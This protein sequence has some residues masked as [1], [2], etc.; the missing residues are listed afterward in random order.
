MDII[1]RLTDEK[2]NNIEYHE[3]ELR[4]LWD[5]EC[6]LEKNTVMPVTTTNYSDK[7]K[8]LKDLYIKYRGT[9]LQY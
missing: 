3:A 6:I 1:S 2:A 5:L 7:I 8:E 4:L 9:D